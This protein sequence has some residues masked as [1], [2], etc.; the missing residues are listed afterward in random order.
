MLF[1]VCRT[2]IVEHM[3]KFYEVAFLH[4]RWTEVDDGFYF[5]FCTVMNR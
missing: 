5:Y 3:D 2:C 4:N 1:W